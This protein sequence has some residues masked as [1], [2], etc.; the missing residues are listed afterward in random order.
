[1]AVT[2]DTSELPLPDLLGMVRF[3]TGLVRF[4]GIKRVPPIEIHVS[5]GFL[6]AVFCGAKSVPDVPS[7]ID[8]L[9]AVAACE[10]GQFHF[11]GMHPNAVTAQTQIPM[12]GLIL[13]VV[14]IVDEILFNKPHLPRR[15]QVYAFS[16]KEGEYDLGEEDAQLLNFVRRSRDMLELGASAEELAPVLEISV[17]QIQFY[18]LK[19]RSVGVV[20]PLR[21]A[22]P[23]AND[24]A[25][26][27]KSTRMR[28]ADDHRELVNAA[29]QTRAIYHPGFAGKSW[30]PRPG[31]DDAPMPE[32]GRLAG[33]L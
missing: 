16:S 5:P 13:A 4:T 2:G 26:Q 25:L 12:D 11:R 17:A 27:L 24:P 3:R 9:V 21:S 32:A 6:R 7:I 10:T 18:L 31:A 23:F 14:S 8:K 29:E 28:L 30:T 22:D 19:L 20:E 33:M 15:E 1:M